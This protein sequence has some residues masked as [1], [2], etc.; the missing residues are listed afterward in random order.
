M[1]RTRRPSAIAPPRR[2]DVE[3]ERRAGPLRRGAR[4]D[5]PVGN[6]RPV[7]AAIFLLSAA[8]LLVDGAPGIAIRLR[9]WFLSMHSEQVLD[10]VR[11]VR[12]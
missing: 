6:A 10:A 7:D 11:G 5:G 3:N 12:R 1:W 4:Q 8:G 2:D 9:T